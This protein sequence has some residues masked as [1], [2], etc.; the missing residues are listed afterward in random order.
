MRMRKRAA[1]VAT[2]VAV[3]LGAG[4]GGGGGSDEDQV[5]EVV[6]AFVEAGKDRDAAEAC[7]L[8]ATDQVKSVEGLGSGGSCTTVLAGIFARAEDVDTDLE[9]Q[10]VRVSGDRATVDATITSAGGRPQAKSVLLV[11]EDGE[12]KIASAGL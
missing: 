9:I 1:I 6:T 3:G 7:S 8:L 4:C 2:L 10:D 11:K 12:W 5:R